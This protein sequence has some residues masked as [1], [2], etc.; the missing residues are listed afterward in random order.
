MIEFAPYRF[1]MFEPFSQVA[2]G[3]QNEDQAGKRA[4]RLTQLAA[5]TQVL[6]TQS[7]GHTQTS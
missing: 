4:Y 6:A 3:Q 5:D 1:G 2:Q 7:P